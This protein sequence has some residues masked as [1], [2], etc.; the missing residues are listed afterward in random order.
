[1]KSI[2][3]FNT[4][5][6]RYE[7]EEQ[8]SLNGRLMTKWVHWEHSKDQRAWVRAGQIWLSPRARRVDVVMGFHLLG[9]AES[10]E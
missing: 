7:P 9:V 4:G 3:E 2:K 8:A 1:M 5:F 10:T 6:D